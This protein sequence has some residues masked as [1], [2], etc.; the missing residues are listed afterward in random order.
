VTGIVLVGGR[1]NFKE[2]RCYAARYKSIR[3]EQQ[4]NVIKYNKIYESEDVEAFCS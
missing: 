2:G 1:R 3:C 4:Y